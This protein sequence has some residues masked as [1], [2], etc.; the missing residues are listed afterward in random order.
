MNRIIKSVQIGTSEDF[1]NNFLNERNFHRIQNADIYV[2]IVNPNGDKIYIVTN[3]KE[4]DFFVKRK[5]I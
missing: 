1:D 5:F 4:K 3:N 2:D